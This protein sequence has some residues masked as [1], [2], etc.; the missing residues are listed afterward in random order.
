MLTRISIATGILLDRLDTVL[1]GLRLR[2]VEAGHRHLVSG[3]RQFRRGRIKLARVAAVEDDFG[4]VFGKALREREPDTLR[5][6]GDE[7]PFARQFEQFKCH[8]ATPCWLR[9]RKLIGRAT[10]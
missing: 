1:G 10:S 3:G 9:A 2:H 5:R 4:A 8:V 6:A 7:R